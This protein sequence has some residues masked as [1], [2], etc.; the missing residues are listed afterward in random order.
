MMRRSGQLRLAVVATMAILLSGCLIVPVGLFT[1][2]PYTPEKLAPL[3][4]PGADRNLV[5][6]KF[7][8]PAYTRESQRYWF[9]TNSRETVGIIAERSSVMFTDDD[10]LLVEFDAQGKVVFAE[11]TDFKKCTSNGICLDGLEIYT[12]PLKGPSP[13]SPPKEDECGVYL[14]LEKLSWPLFTGMVRYSVAGK[15]VGIVSSDSY[16]YLTHPQGD[17]R[18]GAYDLEITTH[19][20][21]GQTLYIRA[22]KK[23]DWSWQTGEDLAPVT[24]TE[25]EEKI[26]ERRPALRD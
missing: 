24:A 1:E 22:V 16:L 5:R 11:T 14:Y 7:G 3:L 13:P 20:T 12:D 21:G 2:N 26:R 8:K 9:Y 25:G 18:V 6:Q 17:I 15:P 19:C 23:T 10:W 4:V